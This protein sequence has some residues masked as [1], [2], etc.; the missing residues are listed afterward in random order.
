LFFWLPAR[1]GPMNK[2]PRS[3]KYHKNGVLDFA[4][5]VG[6]QLDVF[7]SCLTNFAARV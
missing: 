4:V 1:G 2:N 3:T 7:I 6:W 5:I